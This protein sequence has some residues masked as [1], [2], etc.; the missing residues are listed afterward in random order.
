M[1]QIPDSRRAYLNHSNLQLAE[2]LFCSPYIRVSDQTPISQNTLR[3][4]RGI[5]EERKAY[6]HGQMKKELV[7]RLGSSAVADKMIICA[8]YAHLHYC[9]GRYLLRANSEDQT[10]IIETDPR[11]GVPALLAKKYAAELI[12]RGNGDESWEGWTI[13]VLLQDEKK[14]IFIAR[15][16][17]LTKTIK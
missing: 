12:G 1:S 15:L 13:S 11:Q 14:E 16:L 4:L 6:V 5:E 10:Q 8:R 2:I 7:N 9:R 3:P 17:D